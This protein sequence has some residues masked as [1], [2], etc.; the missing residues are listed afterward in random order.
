MN[1]DL[2][3][4]PWIPVRTLNGEL[5]EINLLEALV[6]ANQYARLE[7]ESPLE[8]AALYRL[9]LAV[10]H[11]AIPK[12]DPQTRASWFQQ[13]ELPRAEIEEYFKLFQAHFDLFGTHPFMQIPGLRDEGYI[14]HWSELAADLGSG[15]TNM[16][17]NAYKRDNA[18]EAVYI[19]TPAQAARKLLE[20]QTFALGGLIRK[21]IASAPAAPVATGVMVV[22][23][24]ENLLQTLC[25]NLVTQNKADWERD[26]ALWE[27]E[28]VKIAY[29]K[30]D[31]KEGARGIVHRYWWLTRS[32]EL[33]PEL[34]GDKTVVRFVARASGIRLVD[35]LNVRDPMVTHR[36][37]KDN[38]SE[39]R[40]LGLNTEKAFWRDFASLLPNN[41]EAGDKTPRVLE[42]A[43]GLITK[44]EPQTR[45]K[46]GIRALILGQAND[47][48]KLEMWR[49]EYFRL[50]DA[51]M[52]NRD[53]RDTLVKLLGEAETTGS[54]L[55][56]STFNLA[57]WLLLLIASRPLLTDDITKMKNSFGSQKVYWS[58]LETNFAALLEMLVEDYDER[59]VE[60]FWLL[61]ISSAARN[62]WQHALKSAGLTPRAHQAA[63]RSERAISIQLAVIAKQIKDLQKEQEET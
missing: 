57:R 35:N 2:T 52:G 36:A 54:A 42:A 30:T 27:H 63:A 26:H 28:P 46:H 49:T 14:K 15:S 23:Q 50:P 22:V 29:L 37:P 17:F 51:L 8:M 3:Q 32:L 6:N 34:E 24:G 53:V 25:L 47:Q 16:L 41:K 12:I 56:S 48:G 59:A 58:T 9:L 38:K 20:Y 40:L 55:G 18:N 5:K 43:I 39:F 33:L 61:Q 1:F 60:E 7:S 4:Q 62:A 19:T 45:P 13:N 10:V 44:L 31:P 21:F 11:R